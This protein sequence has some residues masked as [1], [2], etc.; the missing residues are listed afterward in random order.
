MAFFP[1]PRNLRILITDAILSEYITDITSK[2]LKYINTCE[3]QHNSERSN[4]SD[5]LTRIR[6]NLNRIRNKNTSG[7][8]GQGPSPPTPRFGGQTV[9]F[10]GPSVQFKSKIMNFR[11]LIFSF[12]SALLH[13]AR[14]LYFFRI[15]L[16][17]LCSFMIISSYVH[18]STLY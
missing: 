5:E 11:A 2:I 7:S 1:L 16:V 8:R 4:V 15:L 12:V 13:L 14:I 18:T 9:Q 10:G 3:K 17:S 6:C